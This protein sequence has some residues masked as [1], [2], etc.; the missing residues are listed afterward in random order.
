M[1]VSTGPGD[2]LKHEETDNF[3]DVMETNLEDE[4]DSEDKL[5]DKMATEEKMIFVRYT[6]LKSIPFTKEAVMI[7]ADPKIGT[8]IQGYAFG[9]KCKKFYKTMMGLNLEQGEKK[10]EIEGMKAAIIEAIR[11]NEFADFTALIYHCDEMPPFK[12]SWSGN[13]RSK[14]PS[15]TASRRICS[16][17]IS[18]RFK[19]WARSSTRTLSV[20][21]TAMA[22]KPI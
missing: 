14:R 7:G 18:K 10:I 4:D 11:E 15:V 21:A 9:M 19:G 1:V 13:G 17:T 20:C 2:K 8:K 12:I 5:E 3:Q 22:P 6:S 16:A